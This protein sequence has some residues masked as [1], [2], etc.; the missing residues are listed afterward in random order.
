MEGAMYPLS[1]KQGEMPR[2]PEIKNQKPQK[3]KTIEIISKGIFE[4][5]KTML[6]KDKE[7]KD[8]LLTQF[9]NKLSN[10]MLVM[11]TDS[12]FFDTDMIIFK[13][14]VEGYL[15]LNG[16]RKSDLDVITQ[17]YHDI[18]KNQSKIRIC[19]YGSGAG[20][21][22]KELEFIKEVL[23]CIK[24]LMTREIGRKIINKMINLYH[25]TNI[26]PGG[27]SECSGTKIFLNYEKN[28]I[29][30]IIGE[31]PSG[32]LILYFSPLFIDLGHEM[33][34]MI[35]PNKHKDKNSPS[36]LDYEGQKYDNLEEQI[37]ITGLKQGLSITSEP[38]YSE[39]D[40]WSPKHRD[41]DELNERNLA[42]AFAGSNSA[43]SNEEEIRFPRV[44]HDS[45]K[46]RNKPLNKMLEE[47]VAKNVMFNLESLIKEHSI[48]KDNLNQMFKPGELHKLAIRKGSAD[49][50]KL[51]LKIDPHPNLPEGDLLREVVEGHRWYHL[52]GFKLNHVLDV[53]LI[54]DVNLNG[55]IDK[56]GNTLIDY[57]TKANEN[58]AVETLWKKRDY[59]VI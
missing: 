34:H 57:F 45:F 1:D 47:L 51:L 32:K 6:D 53:L 35:H 37:T 12:P 10:R 28:E 14:G 17:I 24:I 23:N 25:N 5:K 27:K 20:Y 13:D 39:S 22:E 11:P 18:S 56:E 29:N 3:D 33:I 19:Y 26:L 31:H 59:W 21:T 8:D 43:L 40:D 58:E 50:L 46:N 42:A 4:K 16:I 52:T 54:D 44:G 55:I 36:T 41:Y 9:E 48:T 15:P 30:P 7:G 49:A 38:K 2:F